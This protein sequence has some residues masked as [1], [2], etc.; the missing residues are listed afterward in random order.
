MTLFAS[1]IVLAF[2]LGFAFGGRLSRFEGVRVRWWGLALAGLAVQFVPL[3]E[4]PSGSDLV[5]RTVVLAASY[6][7]LVAFAAVNVRL[8][9]L[10][11]ILV[12]LTLNAIVITANGGMPVS[13]SALRNSDQAEVLTD[14]QRAG[15]DK[16]HLETDGDVLTFLGDVIA[17]PSPIAQAVSAGDVLVYVGLVWFVI[18]AMRGRIRPARSPEPFVY[19]GR[20]R[21]APGS[22]TPPVPPVPAMPS[23]GATTS[24]TER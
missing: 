19:R 4:G 20:H 23:P 3:P 24:G 15:A 16:H 17:I 1:V 12:G 10:P 22:R 14:L 21:R 13:A 9:G 5:V 2:V 18:A 7:A 6:L 8:P 11:V